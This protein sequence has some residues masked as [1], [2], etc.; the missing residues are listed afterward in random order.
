MFIHEME[1]AARS[2]FDAQPEKLFA[3]KTAPATCGL[4]VATI[5]QNL[6]SDGS[7]LSLDSD[8]IYM[9]AS[10]TDEHPPVISSE[11]VR[12]SEVPRFTNSNDFSICESDAS[13]PSLSASS[14]P[15]SGHSD[16]SGFEG[17]SKGPITPATFATEVEI[18]VPDLTEDEGLG[19]PAVVPFSVVEKVKSKSLIRKRL[20]RSSHL[21][22]VAC[23]RII[24]LSPTS[25]SS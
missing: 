16:S 14:K 19:Q 10:P 8:E 25:G 7:T 2:H 22:K 17:E 3:T 13:S 15:G 20:S 24:G 9:F 23:Q 12:I 6:S 11:A 4:H 1:F 5:Q 21:F 18:E